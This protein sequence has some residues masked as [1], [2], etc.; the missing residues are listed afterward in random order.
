MSNSC[1]MGW[2]KGFEPSTSRATIW[3]P[4]QLGHTHQGANKY[5]RT[6]KMC[7]T[8]FSKLFLKR[9]SERFLQPLVRK[10]SLQPGIWDTAPM[11]PL[12][13]CCT[14]GIAQLRRR[15][16]K[17]RTGTLAHTV[18]ARQPGF[19]A[20][21]FRSARM[22]SDDSGVSTIWRRNATIPLPPQNHDR[23]TLFLAAKNRT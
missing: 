16:S 15:P 4:N 7:A 14:R 2:V 21:G 3:R 9:F 17:A 23:W 22:H 1:A 11:R 12:P 5:Y 18:M 20:P 13:L 6:S 8:P 19:R 10:T